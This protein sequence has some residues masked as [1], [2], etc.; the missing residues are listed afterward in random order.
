MSD[1]INNSSIENSNDNS[2]RRSNKSIWITIAILVILFL[3][4]LA[5]LSVRLYNYIKIDDRELALRSDLERKLELFSVAYNNRS[6]EITVNGADGEKVIAPGTSVDYTIRLRNRDKTA[7][8]YDLVPNVKF[9]S[10]HE[11]PVLVRMLNTNDEYIV[12]DAKTWVPIEEM[13]ALTESATLT[14]GE[15]AEYL[16]QWKWDFE[17]GDDEYD[18]FLGNEVANID[19]GLSVEFSLNAEANTDVK[20]NGGFMGSG[21]GDTV[22]TSAFI[23]L[24]LAAI[25][26][27]IVA[28]VKKRKNKEATEADPEEDAPEAS[29]NKN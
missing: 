13:N 9:T 5:L 2:A 29:E 21:L 10:E 15:S 24:L 6:G 27:L 18:T 4:S 16:F 1:T 26:L 3:F 14:R 20:I 28:L 11:L 25:I 23:L 8:D 17:S 22:F 19:I 7:I 12:G